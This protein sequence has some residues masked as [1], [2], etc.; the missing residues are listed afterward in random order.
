M[1]VRVRLILTHALSR[2][3]PALAKARAKALGRKYLEYFLALAALTPPPR[4]RPRPQQR[5]VSGGDLPDQ[6]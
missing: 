4:H 6:G 1:R 5:E 3:A 2:H